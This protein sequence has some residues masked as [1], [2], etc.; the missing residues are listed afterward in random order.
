VTKP[1][2]TIV[3]ASSSVYRAELLARLGLDFLVRKP[4]VVEAAISGEPAPERAIRLAQ[5]KARAV[6]SEFPSTPTLVIGSD[7]VAVCGAD[8]LD[9]PGTPAR[10]A[11]VLRRASG[12]RMDFH[13]AVCLHDTLS[14]TGDTTLVTC[15]VFLRSLSNAEIDNYIAWEQ[16]FD[17]AG[18]IK[19]ESL[20]IA[21]IEKMETDDPSALVGLPLI[22]LTRL[23]RARGIDVLVDPLPPESA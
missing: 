17:C 13:T 6:A 2:R 18:A 23:L 4:G 22:A 11:E 7:Q 9:K 8:I 14:R 10:A 19:T 5:E 21:L 12:K 16:P 3:L 20:G 1:P 15:H